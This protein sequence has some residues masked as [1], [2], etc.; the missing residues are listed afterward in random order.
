ML[1][2]RNMLSTKFK[3]YETSPHL[4]KLL[5]WKLIFYVL[6]SVIKMSSVIFFN[7]EEDS[8]LCLCF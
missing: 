1:L 3:K 6:V 8:T 7:Q 4:F 2:F 5:A